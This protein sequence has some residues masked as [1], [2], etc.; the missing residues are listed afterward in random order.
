[1]FRL[2]HE[3]KPQIVYQIIKLSCHAHG[4]SNFN[5]LKRIA[6]DKYHRLITADLSMYITQYLHTGSI[7]LVLYVRYCLGE[8]EVFSF[9]RDINCAFTLYMWIYSEKT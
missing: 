4:Y 2:S 5:P 6:I 3:H 7:L 9:R 1:M 8:G